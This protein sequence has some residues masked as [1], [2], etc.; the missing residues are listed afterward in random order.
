MFVIETLYYYYDGEKQN[1]IY[2]DVMSHFDYYN[3]S[4]N[5]Q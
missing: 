2:D 5:E 1:R 4:T 3:N